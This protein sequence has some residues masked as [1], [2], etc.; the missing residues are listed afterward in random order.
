MGQWLCLP[1]IVAGLGL[2]IYC[3]RRTEPAPKQRK[4]SA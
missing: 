4:R 3:S 1:M 2:I